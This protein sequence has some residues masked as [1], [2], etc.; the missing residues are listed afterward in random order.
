MAF[1]GERLILARL[2]SIVVSK[3][4]SFV[5]RGVEP[6][7]AAEIGHFTARTP[8]QPVLPGLAPKADPPS[9]DNRSELGDPLAES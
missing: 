3:Y 2:V 5:S 8:L 6:Y 1:S 4:D 9:G 7:T